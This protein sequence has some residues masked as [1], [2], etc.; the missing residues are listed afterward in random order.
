MKKSFMI[1]IVIGLACLML[2]G[3]IGNQV[4]SDF[5]S[6][7][8]ITWFAANYSIAIKWMFACIAIVIQTLATIDPETPTNSPIAYLQK[9]LKKPP[10]ATQAAVE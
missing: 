10:P 6:N 7:A 1:S 3:F 8:W 5:L 2:G 9:L 4:R